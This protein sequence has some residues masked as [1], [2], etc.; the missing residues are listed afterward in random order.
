M[1]LVRPLPVH[2]FAETMLTIPIDS[3]TTSKN[4]TRPHLPLCLCQRL[5]LSHI[6][7]VESI[8]NITTLDQ[9][10]KSLPTASQRKKG[11]L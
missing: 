2:T 4:A 3:H 11:R 10:W 9:T 6:P 8:D 1:F 5:T 7:C